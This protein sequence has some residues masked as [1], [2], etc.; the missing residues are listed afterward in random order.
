MF[1]SV[2]SLLFILLLSCSENQNADIEIIPVDGLEK[3]D[4]QSQADLAIK[5]KQSIKKQQALLPKKI[6][7]YIVWTD[8]LLKDK[9][10]INIYYINKD[11][12]HLPLSWAL[13]ELKNFGKANVLKQ[14]KMF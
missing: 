3:K 11:D 2:F 13:T 5:M 14:F 8:I 6:N 7:T 1:K 9:D 4:Q 10:I 12:L